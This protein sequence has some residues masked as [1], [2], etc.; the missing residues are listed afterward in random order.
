MVKNKTNKR[1]EE[2]LCFNCIHNAECGFKRDV[3]ESNNKYGLARF[4]ELFIGIAK[5]CNHYKFKGEKD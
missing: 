1:E 2:K 4:S 5:S 3:V